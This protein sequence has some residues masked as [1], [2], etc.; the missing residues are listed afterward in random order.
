MTTVLQQLSDALANLASTTS[1]SLVQIHTGEQGQGMG[2]GTIWHSDGLIV[3]NAHVAYTNY[4]QVILPTGQAVVGNIIARDKRNDLAVLYVEA[5]NLPAIELG[6]SREVET[7]QWVMALGHPFG[8]IGAASAGVIIGMSDQW[9]ETLLPNREWLVANLQLRPGH[10]GGPMVN[11]Y[12]QLIGINTLMN[13]V[14]VGVAV[15]VH[16]AKHFLHRALTV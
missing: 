2:A 3:T 10:S 1:R 14:D 13:G 11:A 9:Q 15:P 6:D 4:L 16:V 12:G 8:M 7:G 5:H